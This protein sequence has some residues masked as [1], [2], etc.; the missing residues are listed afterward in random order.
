MN[1]FNFIYPKFKIKLFD[2]DP[3]YEKV[4]FV[5]YLIQRNTGEKDCINELRIIDKDRFEGME[6]DNIKVTYTRVKLS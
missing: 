5:K 2:Y 3:Q 6:N 1:P 4:S